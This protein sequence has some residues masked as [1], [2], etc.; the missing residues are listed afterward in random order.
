LVNVILVVEGNIYSYLHERDSCP[1][2][3]R[4]V[5]DAA[6]AAAFSVLAPGVG[7]L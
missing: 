1:R 3:P 7:S 5:G 2:S 4:Q 6:R